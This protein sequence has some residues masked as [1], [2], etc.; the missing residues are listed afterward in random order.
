MIDRYHREFMHAKGVKPIIGDRAGRAVKD[1]LKV[2]PVERVCAMISRAFEDPYFV[3][4]QGAALWLVAQNP[5]KYLPEDDPVEADEPQGSLPLAP[6]PTPADRDAARKLQAD[7]E[8]QA[9][10]RVV[11]A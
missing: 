4:Q 6:P 8:Q 1:L 7:L 3:N 11:S 9:A 2:A 5:N 10:A